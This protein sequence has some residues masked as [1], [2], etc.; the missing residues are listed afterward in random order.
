MAGMGPQEIQALMTE[1]AGGACKRPAD[2]MLL[3]E[4]DMDAVFAP[5]RPHHRAGG[6]PRH[7]QRPAGRRSRARSRGPARLISARTTGRRPR[8]DGAML[9][10]RGHGD[11]LR[12]EPDSL[13]PQPPRWAT[14]EVVT[15]MG[16]NGMGKTTTVR[17][18]HH[19][20]PSP[21]RQR[22]SAVDGQAVTGLPSHRIAAA[23]P[24]PGARGPAGV[25]QPHGA[26]EPGG[27]RPA[28]SRNGR[29]VWTWSGC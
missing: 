25:S 29:P 27:H 23:R 8:M 28:R 21:P 22:R 14:G 1:T 24:R 5:G 6:R 13:R 11:L 26:R 15:L 4:H 19:G 20:P 2:A 9:E 17:I 16:R 10:V 3:I 18:G 12:P 7:R